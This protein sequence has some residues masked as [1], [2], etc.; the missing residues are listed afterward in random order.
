M[1][2]AAGIYEAPAPPIKLPLLL[3]SYQPEKIYP[4]LVAVGRVKAVGLLYVADAVAV[5]PPFVVA[6]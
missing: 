6:L 1:I 2:A 5:V 4:V 3:A